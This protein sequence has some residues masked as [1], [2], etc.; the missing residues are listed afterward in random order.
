MFDLRIN[1]D[2]G[3]E[4]HLKRDFLSFLNA[5]SDMLRVLELNADFVRQLE[6]DYEFHTSQRQQVQSSL[7]CEAA[8]ATETG[9]VI[10]DMHLDRFQGGS[11]TFAEDL[12]RCV[13][14]RRAARY[15]DETESYK[16]QVALSRNLHQLQH[17]E[18]KFHRFMAEY[19][20]SSIRRSVLLSRAPNQD[21]AS[22]EVVNFSWVYTYTKH[23]NAGERHPIL[24]I[25]RKY[26]STF[27]TH[28]VANLF[29]M[30]ETQDASAMGHQLAR[31]GGEFAYQLQCIV[32]ACCVKHQVCMAQHCSHK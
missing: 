8:V 25:L 18:C 13:D 17:T 2:M 30:L 3:G 29:D 23:Q 10:A 7:P 4:R 32:R 27:G 9:R 1:V 5:S 12:R 15:A 26:H 24:A 28:T 22:P 31:L 16:A 21:P 19:V 20:E 6:Y 14:A 11:Y